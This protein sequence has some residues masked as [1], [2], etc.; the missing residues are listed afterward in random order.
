[1]WT[2]SHTGF[3][4]H[5]R[6]GES[7]HR[8]AGRARAGIENMADEKQSGGNGLIVLVVAAVSAAY[9]TCKSL[10]WRDF[11]QRKPYMALSTWGLAALAV[12]LGG[13]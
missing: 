8:L 7:R 12:T 11:A 3:P 5:N 4:I 10:S 13:E 1:M 9:F 2:S 6:N